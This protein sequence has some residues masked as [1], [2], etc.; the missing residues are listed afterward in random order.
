MNTTTAKKM[1]DAELVE[2]FRKA[3]YAWETDRRA[4]RWN[5]P[6]REERN[7]L[8]DEVLR[9]KAIRP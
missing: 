6:Q 9:R 3:D 1:T 5:L 8:G 4:G 7:A 2:A